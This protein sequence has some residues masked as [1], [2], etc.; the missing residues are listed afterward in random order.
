[1]KTTGLRRALAI[2][3][4]P[5][6]IAAV[7]VPVFIWHKELWDLFSSRHELRAWIQGW[8]VWAPLVFIGIQAL[9]VIVFIIPGEVAQILGG[10]LFGAWKGTLLSVLGILIGSAVDFGLARALGRP[11]V[12]ALVPPERLESMEKLLSTRSARI[13]FFLLFLIPG[14]PKDILCYVAGLTPIGFLFFHCRLD[15]GQASRDCRELD[16]RERRRLRQVGAHGDHFRSRAAP[17]W[18]GIHPAS[19]DPEVGGKDSVPL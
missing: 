16:D 14:I 9:Q 13:I 11:F 18:S 8:G 5:L 2:I 17:L 7:I 10:Y 19:E 6:L 4:F 15:P 3:G 12:A 1:M